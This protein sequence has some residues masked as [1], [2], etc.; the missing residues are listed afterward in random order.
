MEDSNG[1]KDIT[2][3]SILVNPLIKKVDV[4]KQRAYVMLDGDADI[5]V[6][7]ISSIETIRHLHIGDTI[8]NEVITTFPDFP[9]T[10]DG[11]KGINLVE[12]DSITQW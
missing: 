5:A 7:N 8:N 2:S 4:D 1:N 3:I 9:Y 11:Y 10:F 12:V 6:D